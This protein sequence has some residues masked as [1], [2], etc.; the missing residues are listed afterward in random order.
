VTSGAKLEQLLAEE[1]EAVREEVVRINADATNRSLQVALLIPI[2]ASLIGLFNASRMMRLPE[3][4]LR[5]S[6]EGATL[7]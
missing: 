2:V 6:A 3:I 4:E 1:P 5:A 7:G